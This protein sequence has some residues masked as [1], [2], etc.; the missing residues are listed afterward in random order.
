MIDRCAE[1]VVRR[2]HGPS[3]GQRLG[4]PLDHVSLACAPTRETLRA[5]SEAPGAC[6]STNGVRGS[7]SGVPPQ[8]IGVTLQESSAGAV[9]QLYDRGSLVRSLKYAAIAHWT[10]S[11]SIAILASACKPG[12]FRKRFLSSISSRSGGRPCARSRRATI[13]VFWRSALQSAACSP[14][15]WSDHTPRVC[16]LLRRGR[17][18]SRRSRTA[19]IAS[20]VR[21]SMARACCTSPGSTCGGSLR[22]LVASPIDMRCGSRKP[23][24]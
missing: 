12:T 16:E 20:T 24:G 15:R 10:I 21:P 23:K 6:R 1:G 4:V 3:E 7:S 9:R 14:S 18:Q 13:S 22:S 17:R 11:R 19:A 2:Q 8:S 5:L